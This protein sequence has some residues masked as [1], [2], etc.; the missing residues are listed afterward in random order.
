M[1]NENILN[2]IPNLNY[3]EIAEN[4]NSTEFEK[5][6]NSRR[7]IRVFTET[8]IPQNV[9]QHC[10]HLGLLAPNSNNLQPWQFFVVTNAASKK[11]LAHYCLDQP[12]ATTAA[13]LIVAVARP[14]FWKINQQKML[15]L[16]NAQENK[17]PLKRGYEYYKKIVP[18]AYNQGWLGMFGF[19]KR[20][21]F[22]YKGLKAPMVRGPKSNADMRVWANKSTALACQN[23]ML[24][25]RA[26]NFDTCPMEG[27]DEKRIK[28]MLALPAAAEVCMVISAGQR[29]AQKGVYGARIRFNNNDFVTYL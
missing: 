1:A 8:P 10:M 28:K 29:N 9:L 21:I 26:Y 27:M 25:F 17:E 24:A 15:A 13:A 3:T 19:I 22:W 2:T 16:F 14:D 4:C 23:I 7:S 18:L 5:I 6:V 12:T 20:F 11:E